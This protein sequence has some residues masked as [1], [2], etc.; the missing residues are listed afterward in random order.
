MS[1]EQ[2]R[3][4]VQELY[5]DARAET[6]AQFNGAIV[7]QFLSIRLGEVIAKEFDI[8]I[9]SNYFLPAFWLNEVE[10]Y[11]DA[12]HF[13]E[14]LGQQEDILALIFTQGEVFDKGNPGDTNN[15]GFQN[16]KIE[17]AGI[18]WYFGRDKIQKLEKNGLSLVHGGFDKTDPVY[19]SPILAA[20]RD[21]HVS[22]SY[23]DDVIPNLQKVGMFFEEHG[24]KPHLYWLNRRNQDAIT[25]AN[26]QT[27]TSFDEVDISLLHD[28]LALLDYDGTVGDNMRMRTK[29][30]D[31]VCKYAYRLLGED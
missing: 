23:F 9:E 5:K 27:I 21:L 17:V 30:S 25:D 12:H 11:P 1:R 3:T 19:L 14:N 15:H 29:L 2:V 18:P 8:S 26:I 28:S 4:R 16:H 31:Q 24:I 10:L 20:A 13:L 6:G 22:I 7:P